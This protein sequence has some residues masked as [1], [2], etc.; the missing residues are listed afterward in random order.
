MIL[1][2]KQK[3]E[4][5]YTFYRNVIWGVCVCGRNVIWDVHG[6]LIQEI[7]VSPH[8]KQCALYAAKECQKEMNHIGHYDYFYWVEVIA[9]I[10]KF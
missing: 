8:A 2:P 7:S 5:L 4:E 9:E 1:T 3:A 6:E 10:E